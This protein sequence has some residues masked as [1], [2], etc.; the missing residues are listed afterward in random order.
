MMRT[1]LLL[2]LVLTCS[3]AMISGATLDAGETTWDP[4]APC[5]EDSDCPAE[6][7]CNTWQNRCTECMEN[8]DCPP[9]LEEDCPMQGEGV[10]V[11][12][13][14]CC[15]AAYCWYFIFKDLN[16]QIK[17]APKCIN[18]SSTWYPILTGNITNRST[19]HTAGVWEY[20]FRTSVYQVALI[21]SHTIWIW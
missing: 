12:G 19:R 9:C 18:H 3:L 21:K 2:L 8:Q 15:T 4:W 17:I 13:D 11:Y 14:H 6:L 1:L 5:K 16:C 7:L 20:H 10:C